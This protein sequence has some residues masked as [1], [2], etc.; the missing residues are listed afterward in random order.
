MSKVLAWSSL[1]AVVL[2]AI[3]ASIG[4]LGWEAVGVGTAQNLIL[5]SIFLLV[6]SILLAVAI[7]VLESF[8]GGGPP[9][10]ATTTPA[11]SKAA[12][13]LFPD[14]PAVEESAEP[15]ADAEPPALTETDTDD[16]F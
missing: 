10:A 6:T 7:L 5:G 3:V 13:P 8:A 9:E 12:T 2:F 11:E 16:D 15:A 1:A 4:V 14:F